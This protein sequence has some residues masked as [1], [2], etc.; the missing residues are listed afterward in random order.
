[1]A[2]KKSNNTLLIILIVI[3]VILVITLILYIFLFKENY[4][5][6]RWEKR[7]RKIIFT[8]T[9]TPHRGYWVYPRSRWINIG[10]FINIYK[11]DSTDNQYK[12]FDKL[13]TKNINIKIMGL[14]R[15]WYGFGV[16]KPQ[17]S[18]DGIIQ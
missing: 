7:K 14:K 17:I 4:K 12:F 10:N 5:K 18:E 2:K 13:T 11:L 9:N 3:A 8:N 6:R 15:D 1:M 16:S